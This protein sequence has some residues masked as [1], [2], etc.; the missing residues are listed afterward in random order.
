M[1]NIDFKEKIKNCT[2]SSGVVCTYCN[3]RRECDK[4]LQRTDFSLKKTGMYK[5]DVKLRR[6]DFEIE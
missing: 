2:P 4:V 5:D 1:S 3:A 6:L